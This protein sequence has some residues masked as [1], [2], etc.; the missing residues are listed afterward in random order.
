MSDTQTTDELPEESATV[1]ETYMREYKTESS[2]NTEQTFETRKDQIR[3]FAGWL[4]KPLTEVRT[5]DIRSWITYLHTTEG[6]APTSI[7]NK[8]EAISRM[9]RRGA[10]LS[11]IPLANDPCAD[12]ERGE[13]DVFDADTKKQLESDG[14]RIHPL[15]EDEVRKLVDNVSS[16]RVRNELLIRLLAQTGIRAHEVGKI[17][18]ESIDFEERTITV[19]SDKTDKPRDVAYQ[20]NLSTLMDIWVNGGNRDVFASAED[21]DH[22]FVTRKKGQMSNDVVNSVVKK[23][24]DNAGIQEVLYVDQRGSKRYRVTAHAL[25]HTMG[26]HA[27]DPDH[28][29]GSM[30]LRYLQE[31]MGHENLSTTEV[32]L[33]YVE[34]QA[35]KDMKRHGPSF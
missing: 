21:S 27:I 10:K 17:T 16:P 35:L 4:D 3:E 11:T 32:Y 24:A 1:I 33:E 5:A 14:D 18:L 26:V 25:R 19:Y 8:Y 13:Y 6:Y 34:E 28:G 20:P 9:F 22:L 23:A 29:G 30:N 31:V 2:K 12:F 15:T 7:Q